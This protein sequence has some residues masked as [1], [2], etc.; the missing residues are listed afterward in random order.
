MKIKFLDSKG[1]LF[2]KINIV[3]LVV[4]VIIIAV[5]GAVIYKRT[6]SDVNTEGIGAN[7]P[8]EYCY[9]TLYLNQMLPE[10][11]KSIA[12]G[13]RLVAN[14]K[15]TDAEI[16]AVHEQ[17]AA[18]VG[19]DY[20][21]KTVLTQHPLWK[22][23]TVIIKEK[24]NPNPVPLKMGEQEIRV[25]NS[26]ILKTQRVESVARVKRI[27]FES[28]LSADTINKFGNGII[29]DDYVIPLGAAGGFVES[30]VVNEPETEE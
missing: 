27:E 1:R 26:Y 4:V 16:V 19:Y 24:I 8:D 3:D 21:G 23:V 30:D 29:P 14:G 9:V 12:I 2:G 20:T 18:Y 22:D 13:D 28:E 15:Y 6:S 11:S 5:A 10:M 17:P 7:A 25:G